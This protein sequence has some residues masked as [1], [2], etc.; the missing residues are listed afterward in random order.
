MFALDSNGLKSILIG[1]CL[2][3]ALDSN[4]LK[5]ILIE[6]SMMFALDS[7]GLN[8]SMMLALDSNQFELKY[9]VHFRFKWIWINFKLL[10]HKDFKYE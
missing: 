6:V 8:L 4:G 3:F 5:P 2:M 7:S 9:D 10:K 1:V